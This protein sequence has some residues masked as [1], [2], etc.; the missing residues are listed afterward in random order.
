MINGIVLDVQLREPELV[1]QP[2]GADERSEPGVE[3]SARLVNREQLEIPPERR[4][5]R[6]DQTAAHRRSDSGIIVGHFQRAEAFGAHP[7]CLGR[8]PR[9]AQVTRQSRDK[10][11]MVLPC[12]VATASSVTSDEGWTLSVRTTTAHP[13]SSYSDRS[14][15]SRRGKSRR[16]SNATDGPAPERNAPNTSGSDNASAGPSCGTSAARAGW[17]HRSWTACRRQS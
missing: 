10:T 12:A 15:R 14:S 7:Q 13:A 1:C 8:V 6:F 16:A 2:R 5:P 9:T 17:C 11:H 4:R 3:T